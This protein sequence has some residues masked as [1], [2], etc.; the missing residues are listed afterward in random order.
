MDETKNDMG[1][2][3][4]VDLA[5]LAQAYL[6]AEGGTLSFVKLSQLMAADHQKTVEALDML[7]MKLTG[8]GLCII[9]SETE[10]TLA[11]APRESATL[12]GQYEKELGRE[13]GEAGLEVLAIVL[14]RGPSTRASIDYIRGVNTSST[15]RTL[16][17]RG[18]IER[19]TNTDGSR[20]YLYRPTTELLSHIGAQEVHDAPEYGTISNE[21][22]AFEQ[23]GGPFITSN[24]Q[25][26]ATGTSGTDGGGL[27]SSAG[28]DDSSRNEE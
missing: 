1:M 13:I 28:G 9:R 6:F 23:G 10:A 25:E 7:A 21:L 5:S 4:S 20:E 3:T 22:K 14:Y 17:A 11:V 2:N 18:L 15:I 8:S 16:I 26:Y 27:P 24:N 19:G 12:R